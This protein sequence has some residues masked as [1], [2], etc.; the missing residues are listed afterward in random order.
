MILDHVKVGQYSVNL[1]GANYQ[2]TSSIQLLLPESYCED[3]GSQGLKATVF[4][5]ILFKK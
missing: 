3:Q 1:R 4:E 2:Q 5:G